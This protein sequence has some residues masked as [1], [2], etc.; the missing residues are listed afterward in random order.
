QLYGFIRKNGHFILKCYW[1]KQYKPDHKGLSFYK[2]SDKVKSKEK[3]KWRLLERL[4]KAILTPHSFP[5]LSGESINVKEMEDALDAFP[6]FLSED[7][8]SEA[9]LKELEKFDFKIRQYQNIVA[10]LKTRRSCIAILDEV[11]AT[12]CQMTSG[13]HAQESSNTMRYLL[14]VATHIVAMDAFANDSTLAFLKSYRGENVRVIDNKYQPRKGEIIKLLYDPDKGSEAIR[15]GFRMLQEVYFGQ[16]DGKQR[17]D[18]F[19][20]IDATW[21]TLDCVVYTS[22]VEAGISF[23]ISDYFDA[24]I[25]ITNI[26]TSVH[27][28]AFAQILFRICD[29]LFHMVSFYHNK[30]F[31]IFKEPYQ[32]LIR[33]ELSVLKPEN[34]LTA[35]KGLREW[36]KIS[37]CYVLNLSSA[38]ETYIE[39]EYQKCLL[40]KYFSEILCSLIAS[41]GASLELILIEDAEKNTEKKIKDEDAELI[42]NAPD[43]G[44]IGGKDDIQDWGINN[45]DWIKLCNI[46]F[47]KKFNNP[48]PLQ[49]FRRLA[50][51]RRQGSNATNS[52]EN[53]KI[54]EEMQWEDSHNSMDPSS[55]DLHKFYLAKQWEAEKIIKIREDALLLFGF[56][57]RAKGLPDLNVAIKFINA[58]LNNGAGFKTQ[59]EIIAIKLNNPNYHPTG[60]IFPLYKLELINE[61]QELFDSIPIT[62]DIA[63]SEET[64]LQ[65][66]TLSSNEI[67][68]KSSCDNITEQFSSITETKIEIPKSLISLSS[69]YLI[70]NES[71]IDT[72]IFY[73]QEKFNMSKERLEKWKNDIF[74]ELRDN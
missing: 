32:E 31:D 36:D 23:E 15:R 27:V 65:S 8:E 4:P 21:S 37:D 43:I 20:N 10:N 47:V 61:T 7:N 22:T 48:E 73:L 3:P 11:N 67:C 18:D 51:F 19:A 64:K 53:L 62:T 41:T 13:V 16:M 1:Q 69:E 59:E 68:E 12:M 63:I 58:I 28:E 17:Q 29:Y 40:A 74:F 56:K 39:V 24:V 42:A 46:D 55:V 70:K 2:V 44:D 30:K 5:E 60:P 54:K 25:G 71:D 52:I 72:L 26:A 35:I 34:L 49:Y 45:D 57:T 14:N 38:V 6:N 9:K 50:Y 66:S 33:A